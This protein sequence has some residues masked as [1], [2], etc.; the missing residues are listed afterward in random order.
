VIDLHTHTTASDGALA[1]AALIA[2]A[3]AAGLRV[4]SITDHDSTSGYL[5]A[6]D[7][8]DT[9]GIELVAGIEIS[10]VA[11]GRDV[12]VL[13]YFMNTESDSLRAFLVT[14]REDRLRR[15]HEMR[16]RLAALGCPI[17]AEPILEAAAR[18]RSVGRP[19]VAAALC[20]ARHV[21]DRS[22]AFERFLEHGRPAYVPRR[23]ASP[24]QVIA[25][26]HDA[27]GLASL[28]HPGLYGRDDAIA[29]YAAAGLDAIEATHADHDAAAEARYRHLARELR[30]LVTGG[31]DFHGGGAY[32]VASLGVVIL[33]DRDYAALARWADTHRGR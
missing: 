15:I 24:E 19:Q 33:P 6:R 4:L 26:I 9:A 5:E 13:G 17:D 23:G 12:H 22:E 16:D 21:R 18:G 20:A 30:L 31:S 25:I 28:A 10:A 8:A 7:A 2:A 29:S 1:P 11:D 27:G 3:R 32:R 14:Q